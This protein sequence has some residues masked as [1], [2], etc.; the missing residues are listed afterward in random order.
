MKFPWTLLLLPL[1]PAAAIAA[2]MLMAWL[3]AYIG[4]PLF[5]ILMAYGLLLSARQL[6]H[7]LINGMDD[8]KPSEH[9]YRE[10]PIT[11]TPDWV[12]RHFDVDPRWF[13]K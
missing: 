9:P 8:I 10:L 4:I 2:G 5:C 1:L 13:K 3:I 6:R 7:W 11:T 12:W